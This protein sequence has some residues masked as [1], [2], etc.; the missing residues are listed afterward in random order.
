MTIATSIILGIIEGFT[1]FLPISSTAHLVIAAQWL[2]V[3]AGAFEK[4]FFI[5]IQL[6]AILSVVVLYARQFLFD[7]KMLARVAVAFAPTAIVGFLLYRV[8]KEVLLESAWPVAAVL[9]AGGLFFIFFERLHDTATERYSLA[10]MSYGRAF[11]IGVAQS[12]AVVPGVSRAGAT[13]IMG[14]L[15]G[16][17][18][19]AIVEFSFLLAVPTMAAATGYDLLQNGYSFTSGEWYFLAVG[20]ASSF[21]FAMIGVKLFL[22]LLKNRSLAIF[23]VYRILLGLAFAI[24]LVW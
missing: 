14:M 7:R 10:A 3:K 24:W 18:K 12:L 1:E 9:V 19:R 8:I 21:V 6:G 20:F 5:A 13:V 11:L 16:V 2:G 22:A 4:S 23:G 15:L 17:E